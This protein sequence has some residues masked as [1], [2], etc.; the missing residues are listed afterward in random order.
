MAVLRMKG[1]SVA[2]SHYWI[3][4]ITIFSLC[5]FKSLLSG[6]TGSSRLI[7]YISCPNPSYFSK[8]P[9]FFYWKTVLETKIQ[10]LGCAL[11]F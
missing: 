9:W 1:V 6:T 5:S 7:L 3:A 2:P 10:A 8:K 4:N 11:C